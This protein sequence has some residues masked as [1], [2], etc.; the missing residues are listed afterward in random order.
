MCSYIVNG[1]GWLLDLKVE[2]KLKLKQS[3]SAVLKYLRTFL[4]LE[5]VM[6]VP[7]LR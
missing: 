6:L 7:M 1:L 2:L 4:D 5:Y 3:Q